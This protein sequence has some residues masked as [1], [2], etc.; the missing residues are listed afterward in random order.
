MKSIFPVLLILGF[1]KEWQNIVVPPARVSALPPALEIFAVPP[2]VDQAVDRT[3]PTQNLARGCEERAVVQ[4]GRRLGGEAP[5]N[6]R[7]EE[8]LSETHGDMNPGIRIAGPGFQD[9]NALATALAQPRGHRAARRASADHDV[10]K[11]LHCLSSRLLR[12]EERRYMILACPSTVRGAARAR[13][14]G[15]RAAARPCVSRIP[16]GT[17]WARR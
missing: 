8:R 11:I 16:N 7:I 5:I 12:S 1:P 10:V 3:R 4:R 17:R 15:C 2:S 13:G 6:L 9:K 14:N